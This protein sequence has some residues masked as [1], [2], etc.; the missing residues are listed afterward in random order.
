MLEIVVCED[1]N[2]YRQIISDIISH[3]M[4]DNRINGSLVLDTALPA[5]G[6]GIHLRS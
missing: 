1:N 2:E 4:V 5:E 6:I 3:F